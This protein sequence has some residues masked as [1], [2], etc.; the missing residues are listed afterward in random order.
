[1]VPVLAR[2]R[3]PEVL[4]G[5]ERDAGAVEEEAPEVLVAGAAGRADGVRDVRVQVERA[6]R[7]VAADARACR[8]A[9]GAPRRAC[10]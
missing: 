1:M 9:G 6:L 5:A 8:S 2:Q 7:R 10:P 4:P 3:L